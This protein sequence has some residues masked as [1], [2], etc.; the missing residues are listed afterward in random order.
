MSKKPF[1]YLFLLLVQLVIAQEQSQ[2]KLKVKNFPIP[3][4]TNSNL[5]LLILSSAW[6]EAPV[7]GDEI[8]VLDSD[9]NIVGI[10]I[11]LI[12]HNG[13]PIWGD[14]PNTIVKDGLEIGEKFKVVHW[15]SKKDEYREFT[16][17]ELENGTDTY[18]KDGFTIIGS[19]G[20]SKKISRPTDVYYHI[21]SVLSDVSLFSFYTPK[22]GIYKLV[23]L[24]EGEFVF[25]ANST[26]YN[27][28]FY[29]FKFIED[30]PA[31]NYSV[32][33]FSKNKLISSKSF[34][35]KI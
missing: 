32:E 18:V 30:L 29:S 10:S 33:L 4:F 21:K 15:N 23:V 7:L 28:G 5:S 14:N 24:R 13:L 1:L 34:N 8:S 20:E 31:G 26:T 12:G 16:H 19:L 22:K 25:E 35:I 3:I 17:F 9:G 27:R 11:V 6:D 2:S